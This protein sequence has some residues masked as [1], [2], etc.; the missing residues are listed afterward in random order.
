MISYMLVKSS[1]SLLNGIASS[2]ATITDLSLLQ[3]G[4]DENFLFY[5]HELMSEK[6]HG[7]EGF[8]RS[9]RDLRVD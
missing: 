1:R 5:N 7:E 4:D 9:P 8:E 2:L 6:E 3:G